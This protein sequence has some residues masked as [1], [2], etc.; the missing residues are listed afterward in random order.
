MGE[1]RFFEVPMRL[2]QDSPRDLP[3]CCRF[4]LR[5][6]LIQEVESGLTTARDDDLGHPWLSSVALRAALPS[7]KLMEAANRLL[8]EANA[9]DSNEIVT[10]MDSF[11]KADPEQQ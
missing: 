11:P 5:K 4:S 6:N 7:L 1:R 2:N 9:M 3:V 10:L 8:G